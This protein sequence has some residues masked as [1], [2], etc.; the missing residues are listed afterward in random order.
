[1]NDD[2]IVLCE[3]FAMLMSEYHQ[4]IADGAISANEAKRMLRETAALQKVLM[5]IKL[6]LE[7]VDD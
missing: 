6:R 3:R 7:S 2:G 1:V 5:N 4:S